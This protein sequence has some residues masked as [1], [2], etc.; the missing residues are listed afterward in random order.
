MIDGP[1]T[2]HG[3]LEGALAALESEA[4]ALLQAAASLTRVAKR[5]KAA[6]ETGTVRDLP[7]VLAAAQQLAADVVVAADQ[8]RHGWRFD[9]EDW[10]SSGEYAKELL[11]AAAEGE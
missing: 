9:V 5:A 2:H 3:S 8:L 7:Q 1:T 4:T 10:F 11:A 6:A